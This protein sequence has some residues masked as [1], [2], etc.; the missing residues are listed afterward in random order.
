[1]PA[2]KQLRQGETL[3]AFDPGDVLQDTEFRD[4][5][6][7]ACRW[8]GL[9]AQN[10][11]FIDCR[12]VRCQLSGVVFSFCLMRDA[13][14]ENFAFRSIAW[15][16]LTGRRAVAPPFGARTNCSFQYSDFSGLALAG[17]DFST[18]QFRECVFDGC[19]LAGADFSGAPLGRTAFTRCDLQK[20]DFRRAEAYAIDPAANKLKGARFSF[21][22]V[23]ALL[24][25]TG[26]QI[27]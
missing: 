17:F 1:M 3:T 22:E 11:S 4:C 25:S 9:R 7:E 13:V 5:T 18:C 15:G 8:Q 16:G 20:A 14:M 21:P 12:F 19:A 10:C 23:V 2:R 24:D 26:I 27:E 6:F